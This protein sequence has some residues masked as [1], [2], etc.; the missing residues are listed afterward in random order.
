M[1]S[2]RVLRIKVMQALYAFI[3]SGNDRIDKAED[4]LLKNTEKIYDLFIYQ[5]SALVEI[6]ETA[7]RIIDARKQKYIPT[8]EDI[9]PQLRFVN[10]RVIALIEDNDVYRKR[11][12][13]LR[14]NW[15]E[16]Q[17]FFRKILQRINVT[18]E[19]KQYMQSAKDNF[20][21]DKQFIVSVFRDHFAEC[22]ELQQSYEEMNIFWVD[23]Y[24]IVSYMIVKTLNAIT[25]KTTIHTP[26]PELFLKPGDDVSE[27]QEDKAFMLEL[28]RQTIIHGDAYDALISA[29]AENWELERIAFLDSL[30]I[31]MAL[32]ELTNFPSIPVKVTLNE[33]I[34]ISK[35]YSSAKSHVFING[36][37]DKLIT[38]LKA[39][40][41]IVKTGRGLME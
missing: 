16:Q 1:L 12:D 38:D 19:Y 3:Q 5:L 7:R 11:F 30:L 40:K 27:E 14:I 24:D 35:I 17:D 15:S 2:R 6:A 39:Q 22:E 13:Q 36:I 10:N 34:E 32:A 29:K 23:D 21:A 18:K 8:E 26:L 25:E 37:L 20:D 4:A 41:K 33:Y 28:F 9:S 31:K